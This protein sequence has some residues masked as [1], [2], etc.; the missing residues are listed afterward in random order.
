MRT[1]DVINEIEKV[2]RGKRSV[3]TMVV[4]TLLA[5]GHV[6]LEDVPAP[7]VKD[8]WGW[9]LTESSSPPT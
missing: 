8:G 2:V 3:I 9:I 7:Q 5:G 4:A 1:D 6:L